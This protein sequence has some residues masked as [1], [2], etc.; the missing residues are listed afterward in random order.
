[1]WGMFALAILA[2]AVSLYVPGALLLRAA[3]FAGTTSFACA[4]L[5]SIVLY[6]ALGILYKPLGVYA[7]WLTVFVPVLLAS[8]A[9]FAV[10]SILRRG[11]RVRGG[12][13]LHD[14]RTESALSR[15]R[16]SERAML[17]LYVVLGIAIA[18]VFFAVFLGDPEDFMQEYD[19]VHHLGTARSFVD[20]GVWSP[21]GAMPYGIGDDVRINP[22]LDPG[23][24]PTAWSSLVALVVSCLGV[25][26]PLAANAVNFLFVAVVLPASMFLL[27]SVLF[28][29]KPGIVAF[30]S[31]CTLGFSAFPW[32]FLLFGPL[33]PNAAAFAVMPLLAAC[34]IEIFADGASGRSR[35]G[36]AAL[37][38]LGVLCCAF[39]QP[40]AVFT[41]AVF[42]APFCVVQ[43]V[44]L[45]GVLCVTKPR[46][47]LIQVAVGTFVCLL[48][49]AVWYALNKAPFLQSAVSHSW[50]ATAS[51][52]QALLDGLSLGFRAM[53]TQVILAALVIIGSLYALRERRYLWIACSYALSVLMYVV[54]ASSDG[55]LQHLVAGFWYTDSYRMAAMAALFAIPLA[56]LGLWV[57]ANACKKALL[58]I[59]VRLG[60]RCATIVCSGAVVAAFFLGNY[61]PALT[62]PLR[63]SG[64][65]A[66]GST[67]SGLRLASD[68][69]VPTV[70]DARERDFVRE[71]ERVIPADALVINVPD[72]GSAFAYGV[73]ELRVYYRYLRTYGEDNETRESRAIRTGL[74]EIASND[75]VRS[76]V[77]SIGAEYLL[78]LDRKGSPGERRFLFTYEEGRKWTGVESVRDD[79]PGFEVVLSDDD[80]RLY[81]IDARA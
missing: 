74:S 37:F 30:G 71:A 26:V 64:A 63:D 35:I 80:M 16:S 4:P 24:Y 22:L 7:S 9:L 56:S 73:D 25:S 11:S 47:R 45:A 54:S 49:F 18:A 31:V 57:V 42:L 10:V 33:Y 36:F 77:E 14:P 46:R 8:C 20:S 62:M 34:F 2:G 53:G 48:I 32:M 65:F 51:R 44:R 19:N 78:L 13:T 27:M 68:E 17:A 39:T 15:M 5:A 28:R 72:D 29:G 70:Y 12:A 58:R 3:R 76:A 6:V 50:P 75:E 59:A 40:N 81:R 55:P 79:T 69:R 38:C 60:R 21:F 67:V 23:Y 66:L 61:Y 41:A 1:M 52:S 43:V